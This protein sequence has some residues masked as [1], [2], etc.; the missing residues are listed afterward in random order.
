MACYRDHAFSIRDLQPDDIRPI[1]EGE[2]AQ[3]WQSH[4]EKYEMRI[5][6]QKE[7]KSV[8]LVAAYGSA[9]MY[10]PILSGVLLPIRDILK[11]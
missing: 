9:L 6:H 8:S 11:S 4:M 1:V 2:I 5:Q 3:G 10:T 7:G